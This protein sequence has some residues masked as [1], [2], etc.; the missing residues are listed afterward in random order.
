[1]KEGERGKNR[2]QER[3]RGE[4]KEGKIKW[5]KEC[6]REKGKVGERK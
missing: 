3:K 2:R 5:R 1:M 4:G 6:C